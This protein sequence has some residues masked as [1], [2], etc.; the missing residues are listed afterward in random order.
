MRSKSILLLVIISC[1]VNFGQIKAQ[2]TD[3]I[4]VDC[5]LNGKG[6]QVKTA[7]LMKYTPLGDVEV[8]KGTV[9]ADGRHLHFSVPSDIHAGRLLCED[10]WLLFKSA[11]HHHQD[12][13]TK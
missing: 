13:K 11:S 8:L 6:A 5:A 3:S 7:Q 2:G 10:R 4:H 1:I 9:L 12:M